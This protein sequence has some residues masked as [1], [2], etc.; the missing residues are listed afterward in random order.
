VSSRGRTG[1]LSAHFTAS[2][3][4]CPHCGVAVVRDPLVNLL[5]RIRAIDNAPLHVVSGYRCPVHNAAVGG[6]T[7][8]MHMYG[9]AADLPGGRVTVAQALR[10]G[11]VGVGS[12]GDYAVHVDVRDGRR[13]QWSY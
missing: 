13:A 8:S 12:K 6:A 7:N 11:A 1:R 5:E 9:A 2:E 4:A 10:A 3:F